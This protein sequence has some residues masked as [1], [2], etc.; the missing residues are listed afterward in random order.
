M[1][2]DITP[3]SLEAEGFEKDG[4]DTW[5]TRLPKRL[6]TDFH[7]E[8]QVTRWDDPPEWTVNLV[9]MME[10]VMLPRTF[11]TMSD[12]RQLV[13]VLRGQANPTGE[14]T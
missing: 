4:M 6:K 10:G 13:A 12:L 9:C 14:T 11:E 8:V 5:T 1:T 2:P 7:V 3:E